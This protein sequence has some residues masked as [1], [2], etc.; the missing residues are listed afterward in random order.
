MKK[1]SHQNKLIIAGG[2]ICLIAFIW[3]A[4]V[5]DRDL[6]RNIF[7]IGWGLAATGI[8]INL[9]FL[10]FPKPMKLFVIGVLVLFIGIFFENTSTLVLQTLKIVGFFVAG[11]AVVWHAYEIM[12]SE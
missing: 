3:A 8:F 2:L 7:F 11:I 12:R 5:Q 6:P 10:N 9:L 1:V 4:N